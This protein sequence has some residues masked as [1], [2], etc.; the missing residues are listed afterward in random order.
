MKIL[1]TGGSGL[2]GEYLNRQL[3]VSHTILTVYNNTAGLCSNYNSV[4]ADITDAGR[5]K[6]IFTSFAPEVV[7]HTAAVSNQQK[8][9]S[10]PSKE[11][12]RINVRATQ[13]IAELCDLHKAKLIYTSTDLVYAGYRGSYLKEDAKLI[14]VSLYA[15]TKL[16]GEQKITGTFENYIILRTALLFGFGL[17][18]SKNH[19]HDMYLRLQKGEKARL[20]TDQYRSPLSLYEAARIIGKL[21]E[22]PVYNEIINFGGP[23]KLS[24]YDM[25][26]LLC[27]EAGL[28][29]GLIEAI[30]MA[31]IPG[32]V[33][34][35][36]VSMDISKL[37]SYGINLQ[38]YESAVR[39]IF[40]RF[41]S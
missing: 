26:L 11:V 2:L 34:V 6:D 17:N 21:A 31:D 15:E 9:S 41:D 14:P 37:V 32:L 5:M 27:K 22:A 25:G 10:M 36:D 39:E 24:R 4:K 20:F 40:T 16:M 23:E 8:A 13:N 3:T 33:Q 18:Q 29:S 28:N 38:N 1:I 19:F 12:F 35:A 30:T 7:I